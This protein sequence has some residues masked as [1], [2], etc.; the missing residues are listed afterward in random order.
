[1]RDF[2]FAVKDPLQW[3]TEN[4]LLNRSHYSAIALFGSRYIAHLQEDIG[5][6]LYYNTHV[7]ILGEVT[8]RFAPVQLY[9]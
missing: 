1:M 9:I 8:L 5:A 3:H 6:G 2:V 7:T 4:L